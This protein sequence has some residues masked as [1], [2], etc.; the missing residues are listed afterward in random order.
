M[1]HT[2]NAIK[3][4]LRAASILIDIGWEEK[5]LPK[6]EK[7]WW[8]TH[9]DDGSLVRGTPIQSTSREKYEETVTVLTS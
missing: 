7:L 6:L 3:A 8:I 4:W 1:A 9:N 5:D 2:K